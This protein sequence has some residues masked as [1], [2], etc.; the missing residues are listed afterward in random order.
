M[1]SNFLRGDSYQ[2]QGFGILRN[3]KRSKNEASEFSASQ[4]DVTGRVALGWYCRSFFFQFLEPVATKQTIEKE[5]AAESEL[6][7]H[8]YPHAT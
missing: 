6:D 3:L 1:P 7:G 4:N 2:K 5:Q 8:G